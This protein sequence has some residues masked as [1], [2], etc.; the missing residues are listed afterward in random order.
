MLCR[1]A[2]R[3]ENRSMKRNSRLSGYIEGSRAG[4]FGL[5][6]IFLM[7]MFI[8]PQLLP[9]EGRFR[10][11]MPLFFSLIMLSALNTVSERPRQFWIAAF[12]LVLGLVPEWLHAFGVENTETWG[13]IL[14][15]IFLGYISVLILRMVVRAET[16]DVEVIFAALCVYLILALIW[17][18][19]Y[20]VVETFNPGSFVIPAALIEGAANPEQA[21]S[22]ALNYFSFVTITTL[23]YGDVQP[24]APLARSF[25]ITEALIGQIFLV[26]LIARL[27]AME[28][29]TRRQDVRADR[30]T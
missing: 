15:A 17:G 1:N 28:T 21:I 26:T 9:D 18:V 27:V 14:I 2:L 7:A 4:Q 11:Q 3:T 12:L 6:F 5:L 10:W 29:A 24:V 22:G 30:E 19:A 8:V 16:V 13:K 23:G 20:Q 25:A